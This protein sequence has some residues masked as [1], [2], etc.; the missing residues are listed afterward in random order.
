MA[1][2]SITHASTRGAVAGGELIVR[3]IDEI[4]ADVPNR[5]L[6]D[7]KT[8]VYDLARQAFG[9]TIRLS[10]GIESTDFVIESLKEGLAGV[11]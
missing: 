4:P 1:E 5:Q 2:I 7:G 8:S 10:L 11:A 9:G 6:Y 3:M